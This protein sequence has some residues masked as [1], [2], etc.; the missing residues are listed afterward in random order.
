MALNSTGVKEG[1]QWDFPGVPVVR[2]HAANAQ[3]LGSIPGWRT[4]IP[5]AKQGS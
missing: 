3:G 4:K 1:T 5:H 2:T